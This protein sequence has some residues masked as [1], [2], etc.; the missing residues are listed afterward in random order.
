MVKYW[1]YLYMLYNM[2][3]TMLLN[4]PAQ[5]AK[6]QQNS[7][8][9][10]KATA[11]STVKTNILE[12]SSWM[13]HGIK[14]YMQ[15]SKITPNPFNVCNNKAGIISSYYTISSVTLTSQESTSKYSHLLWTWSMSM[16]DFF[17]AIMSFILTAYNIIWKQPKITSFN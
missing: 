2:N 10:R 11:Q 14:N 7:S 3:C 5:Q 9:T 8:I 4:F 15:K 13:L 6:Y 1:L 12:K 17:K 16:K